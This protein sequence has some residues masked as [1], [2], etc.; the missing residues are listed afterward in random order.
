[1]TPK[2]A[3]AGGLKSQGVEGDDGI[4][5]FEPST[6]RDLEYGFPRCFQGKQNGKIDPIPTIHRR[7]CR[8]SGSSFKFGAQ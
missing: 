6:T 8:E 1:M 4:G 7:R 5:T 2:I 3:K